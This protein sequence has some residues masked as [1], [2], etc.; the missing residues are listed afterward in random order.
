MRQDTKENMCKTRTSNEKATMRKSLGQ[1]MILFL[2]MLVLLVQI[3]DVLGLWCF[4]GIGNTSEK[5]KQGKTECHGVV[6]CK[7]MYGGGMGDQ[8]KRY[9]DDVE[10]EVYNALKETEKMKRNHTIEDTENSECYDDIDHGRKVVVCECTTDF[11]NT[12]SPLMMLK[13]NNVMIN[14]RFYT[15]IIS[16]ILIS[17]QNLVQGYI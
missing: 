1:K 4:V 11:C 5:D 3:K 17:N 10:P 16:L 14:I 2:V 8:I 7:K 9:C 15:A 12:G 6:V 13:N